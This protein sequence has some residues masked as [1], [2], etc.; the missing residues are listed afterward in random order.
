MLSPGDALDRAFS[1]LDGGSEKGLGKYKVC[2]VCGSHC[3]ADAGVF[4]CH[5]CSASLANVKIQLK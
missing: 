1:V 4:K 5:N 2:P 3:S